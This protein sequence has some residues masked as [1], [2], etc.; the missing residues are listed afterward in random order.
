M[1][2]HRHKLGGGDASRIVR[3]WEDKQP[4]GPAA[5]ALSYLSQGLPGFRGNLPEWFVATIG[6]SGGHGVIDHV[7]WID[8]P[9]DHA[10]KTLAAAREAFRLR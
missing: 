9:G 8:A 1:T 10:E 7:I 5:V 4:S 3:E 2:H 6:Q